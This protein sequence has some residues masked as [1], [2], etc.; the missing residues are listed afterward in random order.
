[1]E[2]LAPLKDRLSSI[3]VTT[4]QAVALT[5]A[6]KGLSFTRAV[7]LPV[8]GLIENMSGYAWY[9]LFIYDLFDVTLRWL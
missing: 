8:L 3:I 7:S 9:A 4:P 2:H 6:I 1:M 5:D